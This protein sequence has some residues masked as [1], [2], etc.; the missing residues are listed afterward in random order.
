MF[1]RS[2]CAR[3]NLRTCWVSSACADASSS[4]DAMA[5]LRD[6]VDDAM[7]APGMT[8]AEWASLL[9]IAVLAGKHRTSV[10]ERSNTFCCTLVVV[11][12]TAR[13]ARFDR[14]S[15]SP[16]DEALERDR[17]GAGPRLGD[18]GASAAPAASAVASRTRAALSGSA[19]GTAAAVDSTSAVD[20]AL[21]VAVTGPA[22]EVASVPTA[23][24]VAAS[25]RL[26][27]AAVATAFS[28]AE[29]SFAANSPV[30]TTGPP[31]VLLATH[32]GHIQSP[33]GTSASPT[34]EKCATL[35][36]VSHISKSPV[37]LHTKPEHVKLVN[38]GLQAPISIQE[39]RAPSRV[40][41]AARVG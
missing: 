32:R 15:E 2:W 38:I 26:A 13:R 35:S 39:A 19:S 27:P 16:V 22:M 8:I 6:G 33:A 9:G 1:W 4:F 10:S 7:V 12:V 5:T 3:M 17:A 31:T 36:H 21:A 30:T 23:V 34:H 40:Q 41:Y 37:L 14:P 18:P 28:S 11:W 25:A 20:R 24:S 29:T